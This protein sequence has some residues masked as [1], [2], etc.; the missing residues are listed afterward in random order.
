MRD[1]NHWAG[2]PAFPADARCEAAA[3][4]G[5][6]V[7]F[8]DLPE[9]WRDV[10]ECGVGPVA[11]VSLSHPTRAAGA[12]LDEAAFEGA[13]MEDVETGCFRVRGVT[14]RMAAP[15]HGSQDAA[16]HWLAGTWAALWLGSRA[17]ASE[18]AAGGEALA[19]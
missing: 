2:V 16:R 7:G 13:W 17:G 18:P 10:D 11:W 8:L 3:P 15:A 9:A 12:L 1:K 6:R 14:T 4:C 5:V 19:A